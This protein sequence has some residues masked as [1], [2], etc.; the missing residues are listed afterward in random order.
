MIEDNWHDGIRYDVYFRNAE[1]KEFYRSVI[2]PF[3]FSEEE[4]VNLFQSNFKA[5]IEVIEVYEIADIWLPKEH[6][7]VRK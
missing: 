6:F 2:V 7:I 1:N 3:G 5:T 4:V